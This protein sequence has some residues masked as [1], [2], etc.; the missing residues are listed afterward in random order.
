MALNEGRASALCD[1]HRVPSA[2]SVGGTLLGHT[3][4]IL[5]VVTVLTIWPCDMLDQGREPAACM[6]G[7]WGLQQGRS[8]FAWG[9]RRGVAGMELESYMGMRHSGSERTSAG[10]LTA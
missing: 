3:S 9:L 7:T 6:A 5:P 4:W 2:A 1:R 8:G 10:L